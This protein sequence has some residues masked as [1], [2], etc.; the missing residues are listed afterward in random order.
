LFKDFQTIRNRTRLPNREPQMSQNIITLSD[1]GSKIIINAALSTA[2][3]ISWMSIIIIIFGFFSHATY[4][5]FLPIL[6]VLSYWFFRD[7]VKSRIWKIHTRWIDE[8][9]RCKSKAEDFAL[10]CP[11]CELLAP[12]IPGTRNRYKCECSNKF[13]GEVHDLSIPPNPDPREM[14]PRDSV[15]SKYIVHTVYG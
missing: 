12:A 5:L 8:W 4:Y 11:K 9:E 6:W 15:F 14:I 10:P 3:T 1:P 2:F 13:I 7:E